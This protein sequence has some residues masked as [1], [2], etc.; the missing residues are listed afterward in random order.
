M[1]SA[2]AATAGTVAGVRG[3]LTNAAGVFSGGPG[4]AI[5][6]SSP[7]AAAASGGSNFFP[8]A[9]MGIKAL[10]SL[11]SSFAQSKATSAQGDYESSIYESNA[12]L[13]DMMAA[14][15]VKRGAAEAIKAKQASKRLIGSQRAALGAQGIDIESGSAL[16]IQKETASLGAEDALNI[17]NNA[18]RES[19]GYQVQ[20][21]DLRGRAEMSRLTAKAKSKNTLLTGG[22]SAVKDIAYGAYEMK[23]GNGLSSLADYL[24]ASGGIS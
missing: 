23:S 22:L 12:R 24:S 2:G 7:Y 13:K 21:N 6:V 19:W 17:K 14:D 10:G 8:L 1:P 11:S 16:D 4:T 9:M 3:G 15:A 18:W 20:A 5:S